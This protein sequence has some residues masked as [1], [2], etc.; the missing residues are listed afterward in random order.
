MYRY[1]TWSLTL[2]EER[3]LQ[4][5]KGKV[6]RKISGTKE[7]EASEELGLTQ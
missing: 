6:L 2:W 4:V 1:E 7:Y 3:G 5:F